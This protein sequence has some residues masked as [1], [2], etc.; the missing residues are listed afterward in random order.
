MKLENVEKFFDTADRVFQN[1]IRVETKQKEIKEKEK[2]FCAKKV[3]AT[4]G[5][6]GDY[7]GFIHFSMDKDTTLKAVEKMTGMEVD[8]LTKFANSAVGEIANIIS[9]NFITDLEY[10]C[11]ITP[12]SIAVADNMNISTDQGA[13]WVLPL[14]TEVGTL[15][16][17]L[18]L[19]KHK[20]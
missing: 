11:D 16:I 8:E 14:D 4:I 6:T 9:G 18:L 17:Y 10:K 7:E 20:K 5:V 2:N 12:P 1:M 13:F 15:E 19:K 3:T